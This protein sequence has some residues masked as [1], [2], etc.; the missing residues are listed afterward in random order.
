MLIFITYPCRTRALVTALR[1]STRAAQEFRAV[2]MAHI[3]RNLQRQAQQEGREEVDE[4][5]SDASSISAEEVEDDE[6][7]RGEERRPITQVLQMVQ[8]VDTRW[9]ST[10]FMMQRWDLFCLG[11]GF[12]FCM[13]A[14]NNAIEMQCL[15]VL[16]HFVSVSL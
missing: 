3:R 9:N 16:G 13:C 4:L 10:L 5:D 8:A 15:L 2:Q 11:F 1:A 14:L 6:Y 7:R 12:F